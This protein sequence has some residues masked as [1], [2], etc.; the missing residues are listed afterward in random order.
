MLFATVTA[1]LILFSEHFG[2]LAGFQYLAMAL[3]PLVIFAGR[4]GLK[5]KVLI[6][7]MMAVG[8]FVYE[9]EIRGSANSHMSAEALK[10]LRVLNLLIC[11]VTISLLTFT[12]F[13]T[14]SRIQSELQRFAAYDPLT[15][16]VNRR[17]MEQLA[18]Q[19]ILLSWRQQY[20][21]S[22]ILAD[23]DNFKLIND[24]HGHPVGDAALRHV[25]DL[26]RTIARDS[27]SCCRWGG[28]EFLILLPHTD[29]LGAMQVAERIRV[30]VAAA[31][32]QALDVELEMQLTL[33]VAM[34]MPNEQLA[35][36]IKRADTALYEGK[37]A[38]RNCVVISDPQPS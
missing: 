38:G 1:Y 27:D 4:I 15:Q 23:V 3:I 16:L 22:V 5:L 25:S 21:L 14:V 32:L 8:M 7:L 34:L 12:H 35:D 20:P 10:Q 17:R 24:R 37:E 33:G 29:L 19:A 26:I 31:T 2:P 13:V 6:C 9:L 28:E 11:F 18:E 36:L 30:E